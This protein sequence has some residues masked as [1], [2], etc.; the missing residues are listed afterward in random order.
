MAAEDQTGEWIHSVWFV[1]VVSAPRR[2]LACRPYSV[3]PV[4]DKPKSYILICTCLHPFPKILIRQ[5]VLYM[6]F[7]VAKYLR[8]ILR[9]GCDRH[10]KE[11][12]QGL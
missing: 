12:C 4:L 5:K 9:T 1:V 8:E 10:K 7:V 3:P 6:E 11:V 2:Y